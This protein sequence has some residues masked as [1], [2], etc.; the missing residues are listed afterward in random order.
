MAKHINFKDVRI[1]DF[2]YLSEGGETYDYKKIS[3]TEASIIV[4][5]L[6]GIYEVVTEFSPEYSVGYYAPSYDS[7]PEFPNYYD[8]Q[9]H[10]H[11]EF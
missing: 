5:D 9:R 10:E 8:A 7:A 4:D 2:F 3:E 6:L 11:A 1:G